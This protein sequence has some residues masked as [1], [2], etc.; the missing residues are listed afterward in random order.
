M[1]QDVD[2]VPAALLTMPGADT[3]LDLS[4]ASLRSVSPIHL[5]YLRN[6]GVRAT[7]TVSLME[8]DELWGLI[9]CHHDVPRR[10][11]SSTAAVAE[12]FGQIFSLQI[13]AKERASEL[14]DAVRTRQAHD[15]LLASMQ[16]EE[17]VFDNLPRFHGM[18]EELIPLRWHRGLVRDRLLGSRSRTFRERRLGH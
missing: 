7:L 8:G 12:L 5:E 10:V 16:P 13:E 1:I 2:Y 18:L 14:K 15:R 6:M 4:L 17:T 3:E 9:A 11:S